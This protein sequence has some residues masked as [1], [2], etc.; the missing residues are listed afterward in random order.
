[1]SD[2]PEERRRDRPDLDDLADRDDAPSLDEVATTE[3]VTIITNRLRRRHYWKMVARAGAY[4]LGFGVSTALFVLLVAWQADTRPLV[5]DTLGGLAG[6]PGEIH[7]YVIVLMTWA[8]GSYW[9]YQ[10]YRAWRQRI[11]EEGAYVERAVRFI[12]NSGGR[13]E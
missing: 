2:E 6:V 9:G 12:V 1:M 3:E 13:D 11:P 7:W 5:V 10:F 4:L 8:T